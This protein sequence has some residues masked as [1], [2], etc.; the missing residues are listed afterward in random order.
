MVD[1]QGLM[2]AVVPT[3][4]NSA[5]LQLKKKIDICHSHRAKT[6]ATITS[7]QYRVPKLL[8]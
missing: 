3:S 5:L 2:V 4:L 8:D 6:D 7:R 1:T